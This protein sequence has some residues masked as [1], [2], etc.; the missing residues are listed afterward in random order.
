MGLLQDYAPATAVIQDILFGN[1][2]ID[3]ESYNPKTQAVL[4]EMVAEFGEK[5]SVKY[6]DYADYFEKYDT[7]EKEYNPKYGSF[8]SNMTKMTNPIWQVFNTL[9]EFG[10][11]TKPSGEYEINDQYNWNKT[12]GRHQTKG[13][14]NPRNWK[15]LRY[16]AAY[17][18]SRFGTKE[19]DDTRES[20][21]FATGM[22]RK[23][24]L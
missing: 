23:Y 24:E 18:A 4:R 3:M 1:V 10:I 12:Y 20:I 15:D 5:G 19:E 14:L 13:F 8:S 22:F 6:E 16:P 2:N 17:I 9:G 11:N 21:P 7:E